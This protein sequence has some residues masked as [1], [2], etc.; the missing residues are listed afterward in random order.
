[1]S[2]RQRRREADAWV[3]GRL[4]DASELEAA[5]QQPLLRLAEQPLHRPLNH[6]TSRSP[7]G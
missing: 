3:Y 7:A 5:Q 6:S 2:H 1:M 4:L